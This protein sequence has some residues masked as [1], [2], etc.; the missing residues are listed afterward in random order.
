VA[1]ATRTCLMWTKEA[2]AA[3]TE[4]SAH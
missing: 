1:L 3:G 4:V 2:H